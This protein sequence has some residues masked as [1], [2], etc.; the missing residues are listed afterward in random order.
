M[1]PGNSEQLIKDMNA[2]EQTKG[3]SVMEHGLLVNEYYNDLVNHLRNESPLK[4]EWRLPDW[5]HT[6]K[7]FILNRV[8][9]DEIM[10]QYLIYH[11]LGKPYCR[12]ID[13]D[14]KQHFPDHAD[15]SY[16]IWNKIFKNYPNFEIIGNL[17]KMDMDI[18]F[19]K[20]EALGEFITR[21][22]AISLLVAGLC[23]IHANAQLFGGIESTSFKIKW[24]QINKKGQ[25]IVQI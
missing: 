14:G 11:D 19:L 18:H 25:K 3:L 17:I 21:P 7:E 22:E 5:I 6:H 16:Q 9:S 20:S 24:K 4:F 1:T 2:C 12:T 8:Y 10:R 15:I 23:E 13:E